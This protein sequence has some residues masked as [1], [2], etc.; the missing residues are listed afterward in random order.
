MRSSGLQEVRFCFDFEGKK[1]L[2]MD[3]GGIFLQN[4]SEAEKDGIR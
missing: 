4:R 3:E 1:I 2:T